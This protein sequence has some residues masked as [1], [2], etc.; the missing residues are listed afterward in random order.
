MRLFE[1]DARIMACV[2]MET[3]EIIDEELF[4][5]LEMERDEKI[6]NLACLVKNLTADAEAFKVQKQTFAERQKKAEDSIERFK[7]EISASLSC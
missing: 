5:S 4:N 7:A 2:D 1:I 6:E 3:G